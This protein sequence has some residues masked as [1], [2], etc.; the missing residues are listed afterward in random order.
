VRTVV[1]GKRELLKGFTREWDELCS[2]SSGGSTDGTGD[3][4]E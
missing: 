4:R 1:E 3:L 2:T